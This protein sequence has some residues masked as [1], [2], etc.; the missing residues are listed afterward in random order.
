M[1]S[2][3]K[4]LSYLNNCLFKPLITTFMTWTV[5]NLIYRL[6][7]LY[8]P[9]CNYKISSMFKPSIRIDSQFI[10]VSFINCNVVSKQHISNPYV[11][12]YLI[13]DWILIHLQINTNAQIRRNMEG[14]WANRYNVYISNTSWIFIYRNVTNSTLFRVR[15]RI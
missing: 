11:K 1:I 13:N 12:T 14:K 6:Y 3:C 15:K 10:W 7:N 5:T 2:Y 8:Y 4:V 9:G